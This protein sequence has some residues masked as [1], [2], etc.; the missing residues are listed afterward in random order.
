MVYEPYQIPPVKTTQFHSTTFTQTSEGDPKTG[1]GHSVMTIKC[2]TLS[3]ILN[4]FQKFW[5]EQ[6]HK[7]VKYLAACLPHSVTVCYIP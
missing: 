4:L 1:E 5:P 6:D 7:L 2:K 3:S